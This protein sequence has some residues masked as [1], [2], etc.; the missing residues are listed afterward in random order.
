MI[1]TKNV[2][3]NNNKNNNNN[4]GHLVTRAQTSSSAFAVQLI[5][6]TTT[7][8]TKAAAAAAATTTRTTKTRAYW[9]PN[10][11]SPGPEPLALTLL[12]TSKSSP[13]IKNIKQWNSI[14]PAES[15]FLA[16]L[17]TTTY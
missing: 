15:C 10:L 9:A 14:K 13:D 7:T 11:V 17:N 4:N 16:K 3:N 2:N 8:T 6:V 5:R 12:C 1:L